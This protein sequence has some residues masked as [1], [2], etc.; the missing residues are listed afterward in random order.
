MATNIEKVPRKSN[1]YRSEA[2]V[3]YLSSRKIL[4]GGTEKSNTCNQSRSNRKT[5][6]TDRVHQVLRK[7]MLIA[8]HFVVGGMARDRFINHIHR[9]CIL[10]AVVKEIGKSSKNKGKGGRSYDSCI[11]EKL[12][13]QHRKIR[14]FSFLDNSQNWYIS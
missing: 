13:W 12:V 1:L 10:P 7:P 9:P 8:M 6:V 5:G 11:K 3:Y 2:I 14:K 4:C